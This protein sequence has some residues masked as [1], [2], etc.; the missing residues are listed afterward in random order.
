MSIITKSEIISIAYITPIDEA[1]LKDEIIAT[2]IN[3]FIVS[4]INQ[5]FYDE[6]VLYPENYTTFIETYIKPCI[7][8]YVKYFHIYQL[9]LDAGII[10]VEFLKNLSDEVLEIATDKYN[11]L[12]NYYN[13]TYPPISFSS[14]QLISGFLIP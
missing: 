4:V 1:D 8:F 12:V 6:I 3:K 2:V 7:A 5:S 9:S 10:Q 13:L 11:L 14:K